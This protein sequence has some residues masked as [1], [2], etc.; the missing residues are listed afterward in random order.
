[1]DGWWA[2]EARLQIVSFA[3]DFGEEGEEERDGW[4]DG[5]ALSFGPRGRSLTEEVVIWMWWV[6]MMRRAWLQT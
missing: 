3:F 6:L 5:E 1:M 2:F 4:L